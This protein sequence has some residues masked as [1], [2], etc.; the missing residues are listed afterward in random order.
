MVA[1]ITNPL[2]GAL[3]FNMNQY[4]YYVDTVAK[5]RVNNEH[6]ELIDVAITDLNQFENRIIEICQGSGL[7]F[8]LILEHGIDPYVP[9][10]KNGKI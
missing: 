2:Y 5:M 4:K 6:H 7:S 1:K 9:R 3:N 10:E 8:D